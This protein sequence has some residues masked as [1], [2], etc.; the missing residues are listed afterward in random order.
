M[1]DFKVDFKET[2]GIVVLNTEGYLNNVGGEKILSVCNTHIENGKT[3]FLINMQGTKV[4]NSIGVSILIEV[5]EKLQGINGRIGFCHLAPIVDKT[6]TIM[7]IS[8]YS[9][10][11]STEEEGISAL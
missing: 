5:I 6:F 9:S 11:F 3:I 7:G 4:V 10:I 8:K 1:N 2:N